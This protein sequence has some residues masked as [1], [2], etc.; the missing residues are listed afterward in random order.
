MPYVQPG[1]DGRL[2]DGEETVRLA[3]QTQKTPAKFEVRYGLD[4]YYAQTA[5][6]SQSAR[7]N[8][9]LGELED[10]FNYVSSLSG[11][12]LGREYFYRVT[13]NGELMAEGFFTTRQP[14][15]RSI[16]FVSFG[17]NSFGDIS[18]RAIA[19]HAFEAHPDLV[20]NTGDNVYEGGL[21]NEYGRYFF[22]VYNADEAGLRSGGPL[23][24]APS[25]S[26]ASS[27]ITNV[28]DKDAA[29]APVANFDTEP[30]SLG[31]YTNF[32]LPLNGPGKPSHPTPIVGKAETL[33]AFRACADARFPHGELLLRLRR[34]PFPLPQTRISIDPTDPICDLEFSPGSPGHRRALEIR[35]LPPS[36]L[37]CRQALSSTQVL[38]R[39]SRNSVDLALTGTTPTLWSAVSSLGP[40][41]SAAV[42]KAGSCRRV[43]ARSTGSSIARTPSPNPTA[44]SIVTGAESGFIA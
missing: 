36:R 28:Y 11:L 29:G 12:E 14:R 1:T 24:R 35:R 16:R 4:K 20:V 39:S 25:H 13:C 32:Y 22:P 40:G 27:R 34:R 19:F 26:T 31:F 7:L 8:R 15:G 33:A 41:Q 21:D 17:D 38:A 2:R 3:W 18:D 9:G 44:S 10:R 30:D 6:V 37:Q 43:H 42:N 23:L 5:T